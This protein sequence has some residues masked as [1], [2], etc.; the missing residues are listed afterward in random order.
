MLMMTGYFPFMTRPMIRSAI[1]VLV[2]NRVIKKGCFNQNRFDKTNWYTF[3]DYGSYL[4]K[5]GNDNEE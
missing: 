3:T 2:D 1:G 4:M 5:E